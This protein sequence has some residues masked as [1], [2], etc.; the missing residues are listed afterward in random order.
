MSVV[1][2]RSATDFQTSTDDRSADEVD[3]TPDN[4][5]RGGFCTTPVPQ[6]WQRDEVRE[7]APV[8][9]FRR[10]WMS[11]DALIAAAGS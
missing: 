11:A 2:S 5:P 4:P 9:G 1:I 8:Y 10:R 6:E 7:T 3:D